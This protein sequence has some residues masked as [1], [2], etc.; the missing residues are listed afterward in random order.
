MAY[1]FHMVCPRCNRTSERIE[2]RSKP[3]PSVSC[4]ECLMDGC[5]IVH[6]KVVAFE[7]IGAEKK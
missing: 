6:L 7:E 4:G 3:A 2:L 5:E 1:R